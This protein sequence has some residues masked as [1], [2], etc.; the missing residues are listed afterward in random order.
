MG[1]FF[2]A[3]ADG[4]LE[5]SWC[6]NRAPRKWQPM[7]WNMELKTTYEQPTIDNND[8]YFSCFSWMINQR[9]TCEMVVS[10]LNIPF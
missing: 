1:F 7:D 4:K 2:I 10:P 9:F 5:K 8:I 3:Q 6:K